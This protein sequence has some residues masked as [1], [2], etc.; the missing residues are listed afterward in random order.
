MRMGLDTNESETSVVEINHRP[1]FPIYQTDSKTM[2]QLT[3]R[4]QAV[5]LLNP[6]YC[7]SLKGRPRG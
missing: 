4:T 2:R 7:T 6:L 5:A 1:P 3:V